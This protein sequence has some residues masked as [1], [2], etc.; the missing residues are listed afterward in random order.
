MM[1]D[2]TDR[3]H[4]MALWNALHSIATQKPI[5]AYLEIGVRYGDSL[6]SVLNQRFPNRLTLCDTWGGEYGGEQFG[7]PTHIEEL[8][9]RM[10][11]HHPVTFLNGNSHDLLKTVKEQFD[12]ITVDGDHSA[13]GA[14]EDLEDCWKLLT[15]GGLLLFDD[16][17]H[18]SH[19]ELLG[20]F[21]AFAQSVDG[22][23]LL[24]DMTPMGVGVLCKTS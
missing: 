24:E 14:R 3:P 21:R 12:L 8:L 20:V 4:K 15:P 10:E 16:L 18:P 13:E 11:Y 1:I 6:V 23:V 9:A 22:L 7:G 2:W 19:P 5:D 17:S